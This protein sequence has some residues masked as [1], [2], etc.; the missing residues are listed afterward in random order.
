MSEIARPNR[1]DTL[2]TEATDPT[3]PPVDT[4]T[5]PELVRLMNDRDA[6]IPRAVQHALPEITTAIAAA[7]E[8]MRAGGRLFYVGAGTSG[9]LGVLDASEIPPTFGTDPSLVVGIIAGG[10]AALVRSAE[11]AED[12]P[13]DGARALMGFALNPDDTVVGVASSGRTPFVL[14]AVRYAAEQGAATIGVSCTPHAELSAA[15]AYPIEVPVGPEIVTGST[16]LGAGTATKM[17]LNMISTICMIRLGKTYGS[18]MVDVRATNQK[19][20]HRAIRIV[21]AAAK[22]DEE[23]AREALEATDWHAKLAIAVLASGIDVAEARRRLD[24]AD[25][26]LRRVIGPDEQMDA[27]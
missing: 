20:V 26:V 16:R 27:A 1:L 10:P 2:L 24:A 13:E 12:S 17:V 14:G 19:L 23:T 5:V 18:L 4:L 6:E 9:R 25:G 7:S 15:T 11:S 3:R 21:Q 22:V 8:R